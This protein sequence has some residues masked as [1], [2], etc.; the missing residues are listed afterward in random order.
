MTDRLVDPVITSTNP[1][2]KENHMTIV[3]DAKRKASGNST[4]SPKK[5]G[6]TTN[7]IPWLTSMS[8]LTVR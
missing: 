6:P 8:G 7:V 2:G 5:V 1:G 3:T 4:T